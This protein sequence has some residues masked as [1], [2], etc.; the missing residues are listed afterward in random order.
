[1]KTSIAMATYNGAK[2]LQ[3]QLDSFAAQTRVP[4][5][6]VICDDHSSDATVATLSRFAQTASFNVRIVV[7]DVNLGFVQN[8]ERA[9][10]LCKGDLIFLS[11]Q[12]DVWF[13]SKIEEIVR[14]MEENPRYLVVT[15]DQIITDADLIPIGSVMA[16]IRTGGFEPSYLVAG[17]CTAIRRAWLDVALPVHRPVTTIGSAN[18]PIL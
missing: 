12:D 10:S 1:M 9:L 18:W 11:D 15:N 14:Y 2:Y 3:E 5:E 7:N 16:N 6:L 13:D 4:D 8:F 17:C